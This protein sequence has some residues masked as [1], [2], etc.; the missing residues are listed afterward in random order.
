MA[1]QQKAPNS[2]RIV[3]VVWYKVLPPLFGGQ[4]GV[5]FFN[6]YLGR[7]AP[8]TCLC[9]KNNTVIPASYHIDATL[10]VSKSQFLNPFC[11]WKIF[12]AAKRQKA[13]HLILEFPYYG[14]AGF[15][16]KMLTGAKL[17]VHAHNIE[18]H[19]FKTQNKKW[20]R[21]LQAYEKWTLRKANG[22]FFKTEKEKNFAVEH[23]ALD[24][25]NSIVVPYGTVA[26]RKS[27][28]D[29]AKALLL[30][31]HGIHTGTGLLLFAGTL[32][33]RPNAQALTALKKKVI[34]LLNKTGLPYKIIV[35]G[36]IVDEAFSYL[37]NIQDPNL[38]YAG[39]VADIASYF[40]AADAFLNPVVTG[41][42]VQTKMVDALGF[43]LNVVCF[44][45]M[46]EGI[47][48]ADAKIFTAPQNDWQ[49]FTTAIGYALNKNEPTPAAFFEYHN[50]TNIAEKT[51]RFI[52]TI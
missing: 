37:R 9:S 20:W 10:P 19:R 52:Q 4:K 3:S 27:E 17:L 48:G 25:K 45:G 6:E 40:A 5:A 11:W 12:L 49:A 16:T 33:Y 24:P 43:N 31:R 8:L 38:L 29:E 26:G 51:Y 15:F 32:D 18:S 35:C 42:G 13:T 50:W 2:I 47:K 36:R 14:L 46:Q 23:F 22:I 39:N 1:K 41:G 28:K 30:Q 34:P 21:L 44:D 7:L